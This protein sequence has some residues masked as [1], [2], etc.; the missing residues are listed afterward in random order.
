MSVF[1]NDVYFADSNSSLDD[2][3]VNK[4]AFYNRKDC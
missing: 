2:Q 4:V 1:W 3:I